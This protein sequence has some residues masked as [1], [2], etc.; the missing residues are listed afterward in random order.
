MGNKKPGPDV[1]GKALEDTL[2]RSE[3][4]GASSSTRSLSGTAIL[5]AYHELE[6][7]IKRP[8]ACGGT[9]DITNKQGSS[10][11]A[12]KQ[13]TDASPGQASPP[14]NLFWATETG[15]T[16]EKLVL[17]YE[18]TSALQ[19]L[20]KECVP[21]TFGKGEADVLDPEYRRAG[22]MDPNNFATSFHPAD[23]GIIENVERVLL[24]S[25]NT[26]KQ[27]SLWFRKLRAELYN[28]NVWASSS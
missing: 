22:K 2:A 21:A 26:E 16:A 24:P 13:K 10:P 12:K 15:S 4:E 11:A 28:L 18:S 8:F 23:F 6:K 20:V 3:N 1:F 17:P 25:I 14:V 5:E 19:Q 7:R 27:N 9:I